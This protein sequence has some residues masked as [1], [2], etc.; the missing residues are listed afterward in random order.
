MMTKVEKDSK[1]TA[2]EKME[3]AKK[4][5]TKAKKNKEKTDEKNGVVRI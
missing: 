2:N 1:T 3:K 4:N 5:F